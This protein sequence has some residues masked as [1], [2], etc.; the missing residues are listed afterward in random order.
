MVVP[1]HLEPNAAPN[2]Y[3][4]CR[5][6]SDV[7]AFFPLR[8]GVN[9][10][11]ARRDNDVVLSAPG[12]SRLHADLT[13][14]DD[15]V[16]LLDLAS[17][18]GITVNG[19]PFE[20]GRLEIG[21][22]IEIG[23]VC[24]RLDPAAAAD[25][26]LAI[27]LSSR[28]NLSRSTISDTRSHRF[29][30]ALDPL[31]IVAAFSESLARNELAASG[32]ALAALLEPL[33]AAGAAWMEVTADDSVILRASAGSLPTLDALAN[34]VN[35]TLVGDA[36]IVNCQDGATGLPLTVVACSKRLD[37][38]G[39]DHAG[40]DG[41]GAG[42]EVSD[43]D[44]TA[45]VFSGSLRPAVCP[46]L[47]GTLVRMASAVG[48]TVMSPV[49]ADSQTDLASITDDVLQFPA[50]YVAGTSPAASELHREISLVCATQ[51][52]LLILGETGVGK[53]QI[54][55]LIHRSSDRAKGPFVAINCAA[56][57]DDL[58]E[59]EL[60]G[61]GRGVATGVAARL[62]QFRRAMGGTLFLDEIGELSSDIQVKLL[63]ALQEHE[64]QPLGEA[65]V[66]VDVR[67]LAATNADL[68]GQ[69][70][71]G[72]F[73]A[74]LYYR[75]AGAV[76]EIP[77][78]RSRRDDLPA[79]VEH[80]VRRF[81]VEAKRRVRG[82]T[83]E[84]LRLLSAY[85]WPGNVRELENEIRRLVLR[86]PDRQ[87]LRAAAVGPHIRQA[88]ADMPWDKQLDDIEE[89][90]LTRVEW[91]TI[92]RALAKTEG[93]QV[94][95]ARLLGISRFTLRRRIEQHGANDTSG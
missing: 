55:S 2:S 19:Q 89:L 10:I 63:R 40:K 65:P 34:S 41:A 78:L 35:E 29:E 32:L 21:D 23:T 85:P 51:V 37:R 60:F 7:V 42:Q 94:Q 24:L 80:F 91:R 75:L 76:I 93:N 83:V 4:L 59:A 77:P 50:D 68:R 79:L 58:V 30:R 18:N 45:L 53:E 25:V 16:S 71:E 26:E 66:A 48:Q 67:I 6:D 88:V 54:A 27:S 44:G 82:V 52:P 46:R 90:D 86:C 72:G 95:A 43:R 1:D 33:G 61:I 57:P 56:I 3:G 73:R 38:R 74:D 81:A 9:H 5:L 14:G 92:R 15:G 8:R 64:V 47:L 49:F 20:H 39:V 69:I 11:G 22:E 13:L 87:P 62:G 17:K 31:A 12:V 70:E 28:P 36:E 84:A